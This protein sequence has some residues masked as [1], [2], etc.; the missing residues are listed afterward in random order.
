MGSAAGMIPR[1][2]R[3]MR[4]LEDRR[5]FAVPPGAGGDGALPGDAV[6]QVTGHRIPEGRPADR[7]PDESVHRRG[8]LEPMHHL[9]LVG[10]APQNDAADV[11]PAAAPRDGDGLLAVRPAVE[12]FDLPDV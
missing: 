12:P 8:R 6:L 11:V 2:A 4:P 1:L 5:P 9:L 3:R 10:A 7:E